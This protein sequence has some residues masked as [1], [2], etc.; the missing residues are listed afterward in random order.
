MDK[1]LHSRINVEDQCKARFQLGGQTYNNIIVRNLG[2]NGCCIEMPAKN[3]SG[4]QERST[5]DRWEL[6]HPSLPKG[7]IKARVVWTHGQ[8]QPRTDTIETGVQFLD[9]PSD[10]SKDLDRYVTTLARSN[11]SFS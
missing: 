3:V 2:A 8:G 10:Y 9:V 1:R 7:T 4:L 5:L 6:I 11:P